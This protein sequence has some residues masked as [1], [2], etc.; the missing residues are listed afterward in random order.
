MPASASV[1]TEFAP[2]V[3]LQTAILIYK[4]D[5]RQTSFCTIHTVQDQ[6]LE[7]GTLLNLESLESLAREIGRAHV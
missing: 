2:K 5:S 3:K 6:Q 4:D 1:N 7:A